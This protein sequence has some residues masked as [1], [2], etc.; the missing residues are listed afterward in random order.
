ML[1]IKARLTDEIFFFLQNETQ[2]HTKKCQVHWFLLLS[3]IID[4]PQ[5]LFFK[6]KESLQNIPPQVQ[7]LNTR[8]ML[9]KQTSYD[10]INYQ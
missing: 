5:S 2:H 6:K 7:E 8:F 10:I 1:F 3:E 4:S 9:K